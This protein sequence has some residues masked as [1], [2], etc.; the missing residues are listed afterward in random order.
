M[1]DRQRTSSDVARYAGL[2]VATVSRVMHDSPRV[3]PE[4]RRR[5]EEAVA[6]LGYTP[7]ALARGLVTRTTRTIAVLVSSIADPF[8]AEVIRGVEDHA[9]EAGYAAFIASS[10]EDAGREEK[11]ISL[12]R[13][14]RVDGI[15]IGASSRGPKVLWRRDAGAMPVVFMN[16][17]HIEPED[18]ASDPA[19]ATDSLAG[20][21]ATLAR[22]SRIAGD[23]RRGA[24][25]LINHLLEL[26]H[27][28]IAY[29]GATGRASSLRRLHGFRQAMAEACLPIDEAWVIATDEGANAGELS[30]FRLLTGE[31]RPTALLCYDD[32]TALG[33]LRA[34]RALGLRCPGDI[35]VVGFDDIPIAA[36]LEPP[37]TTVR[38]PM[39]EMGVRAMRLLIELLHEEKPPRQVIMP[40]ELVARASSG[41][42][43][44]E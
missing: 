22:T 26:G 44:A 42:A 40:G 1:H 24:R 9:V 5:V 37:L 23:D 20:E 43:P 10:Y 41:P 34:T 8:W 15:V 33:A 16:N 28:R 39:H 13:Q 32:M 27:R 25:L 35:S 11:A 12:F 21:D 6:A 29:I 31:S 2:S 18:E 19:P 3:S 30:A 36:Y 4:A 17:E 7:N 38:Q 14:K